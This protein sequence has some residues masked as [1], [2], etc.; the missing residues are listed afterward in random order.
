MSYIYFPFGRE[1]M[2]TFSPLA[3]VSGKEDGL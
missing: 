3:L 1:D 2:K